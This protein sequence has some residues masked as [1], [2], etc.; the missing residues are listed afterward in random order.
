MAEEIA[1]EEVRPE[2]LDEYKDLFVEKM[3]G[4]EEKDEDGSDDKKGDG[5][6]STTEGKESGEG[7]EAMDIDEQPKEDDGNQAQQEDTA[8]TVP[9]KKRRLMSEI[10]AED[11]EKARSELDDLNV[12]KTEMVWLLRQVITA[13]KKQK[14]EAAAATTAKKE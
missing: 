14:D 8:A 3:E 10:K 1:V 4:E 9:K 13:E 6:G 2:D 7:G 5:E 12:A 11:L